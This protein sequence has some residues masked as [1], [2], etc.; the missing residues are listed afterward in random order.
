M[1]KKIVCSDVVEIEAPIEKVWDVLVDFSEYPK[2]NPF[3]YRIETDLDIGSP[4]HLYFQ[5]PGRD[6]RQQVEYVREVSKPHTVSWGVTPGPGFLLAAL[7]EQR[8]IRLSDSRC[9]YH[10]TDALTG[11]LAPFVMWVFARPMREGFNT[12]A[13][14]LKA[15]AEGI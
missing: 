4:V 3:T 5:Y 13:Y 15:Q 1:I 8:L 9:S 6:K 10:T 14:A 7:R 12:M 11:L 2:W